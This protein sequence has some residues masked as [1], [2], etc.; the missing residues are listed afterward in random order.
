MKNTVRGTRYSVGIGEI[1]V[2]RGSG[3]LIAHA[4]GSCLGL[5]AYD[6]TTRVAGLLHAML[7]RAE[8]DPR[9]AEERPA[10]FVETGVPH[11]LEEFRAAGG[12]RESMILEAAGCGS[13]LGAEATFRVGERNHEVLQEIL[14]EH[15]LRLAAE[16][17]GGAQSRTL[18][19]DA[20]TGDIHVCRGVERWPL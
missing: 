9:R 1:R 5:V 4:L 2:V 7:S 3:L 6:P 12:R 10:L 13:P 20:R 14:R 11:L 19:V 18:S 16:E 17:I 8:I 15:R